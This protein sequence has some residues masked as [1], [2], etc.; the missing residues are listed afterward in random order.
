MLLN[1]AFEQRNSWKVFA[2]SQT[3]VNPERFP[4]NTNLKS[5]FE[6]TKNDNFNK[7][8]FFSKMTRE[9]LV[10]AVT[11][12][13]NE[14]PLN[15]FYDI[16]IFAETRNDLKIEDFRKSLK[17]ISIFRWFLAACVKIA[18]V[19]TLHVKLPRLHLHQTSISCDE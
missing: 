12:R 5:I 16:L 13:E 19:P 7:F 18:F 11:T 1:R 3:F 8:P 2:K 17:G 15:H 6:I 10:R 14:I 9:T 4:T